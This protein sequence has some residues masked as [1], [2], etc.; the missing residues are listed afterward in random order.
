MKG[1]VCMCAID[2]D[3]D[4]ERERERAPKGWGRFQSSGSEAFHFALDWNKISTLVS[5]KQ[6][7]LIGFGPVFSSQFSLFPLYPGLLNFLLYPG[8]GSLY[9]VF[10]LYH[11][12][13]PGLADLA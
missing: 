2:R 3:R 10:T 6:E 4:R 12:P 9:S 11:R 7:A 1:C 13:V 8:L 5:L